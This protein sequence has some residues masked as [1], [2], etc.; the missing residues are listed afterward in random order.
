MCFHRSHLARKWASA[1]GVVALLAGTTFGCLNLDI[2]GFKCSAADTCP[3]SYVCDRSTHRC[4]RPGNDASTD[5]VN[6]ALV[7]SSIDEPVVD[8][9]TPDGGGAPDGR[10]DA[11]DG[12]SADAACP[13]GQT[14]HLG[15]VQVVAGGAHTCAVLT[16][17]SMRCW[18]SNG[19]GQLGNNNQGND[20][21]IPVVVQ[22]FGDKK[23][24]AAGAGRFNT[25]A[26]TSDGAVHCWGENA[27]G[28]DGDPSADPSRDA[29]TAVPN[30]SGATAVAVGDHHACAVVAGGGVKCWGNNYDGQIGNKTTSMTEFPT[31]AL[32]AAG[33]PITG[34]T[35]V[36]CG[37]AS[38]C[39]LLGTGSV[40]CWGARLGASGDALVPE[41][42]SPL[43]GATSVS[44]G[45]DN[46]ACSLV[47]AGG[48]RC[49]GY[50]SRGGLGDNSSPLAPSTT[51]VALFGGITGFTS[52]AA[53]DSFTCG[54]LSDGTGRCW[55]KG[56]QLGHSPPISDNGSA[57]TVTGLSGAATVSAGSFHACA[58]L[59]NGDVMCWGDNSSGALGVTDAT[60]GGTPVAVTPW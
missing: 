13:T 29:S 40:I 39:A 59:K 34:A 38:T 5:Q 37:Y 58:V 43:S 55:G 2:D 33:T 56:A 28:Q 25:C 41:T 53:G 44:A 17:G 49:W 60:V 20:S 27:Y 52:L 51:A 14:C 31:G 21:P 16:D 30:V 4:L 42:V 18:G 19:D 3:T 46:H 26:V 10:E 11:P 1:I 23:V 24:I 48:V 12:Q 9:G 35:A 47:A 22:G 54:T 8:A 7:D 36:A 50:N 15:A 45:E 6:D 57:V 32:S